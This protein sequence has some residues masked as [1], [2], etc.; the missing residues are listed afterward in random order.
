MKS[1]FSRCFAF[2]PLFFFP[3]LFLFSFLPR[4]DE[5]SMILRYLEQAEGRP[6]QLMGLCRR[7]H[8]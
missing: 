7:S 5:A 4:N 8:E 1:D 3:F 2:L 6:G